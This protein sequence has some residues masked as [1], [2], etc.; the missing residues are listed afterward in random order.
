MGV[1][2]GGKLES[3]KGK[4]NAKGPGCVKSLNTSPFRM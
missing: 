1:G 3:L 2:G 4:E